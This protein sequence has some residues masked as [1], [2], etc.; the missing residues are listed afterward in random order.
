MRW[1][2]ASRS[3]SAKRLF[4][5]HGLVDRGHQ[6]LEL[7]VVEQLSLG[8]VFGAGWEPRLLGRDGELG[9]EE[10]AVAASVRVGIP[11]SPSARSNPSPKDE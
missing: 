4:G 7:L 1:M 2:S 8:L 5:G 3:K 9:H 6:R 11:G 10:S